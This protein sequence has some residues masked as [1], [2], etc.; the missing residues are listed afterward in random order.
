MMRNQMEERNFNRLT[1]DAA[2]VAGVLLGNRVIGT[3]VDGRGNSYELSS[4]TR[5]ILKHAETAESLDGYLELTYPSCVRLIIKF[6]IADGDEVYMYEIG[7][8][9]HPIVNDEIDYKELT[10]QL[11]VAISR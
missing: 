9:D 1:L 5:S 2:S 11:Y 6:S 4:V 7:A 10:R 8:Y 3:N